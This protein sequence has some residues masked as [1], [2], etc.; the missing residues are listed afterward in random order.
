MNDEEF[1]FQHHVGICKAIV[2]PLRQRIIETLGPGSRNVSEMQSELGVSMSNLSNHLNILYAAGVVT[3]VKEGSFTLY[4]LSEP[5]LLDVLVRM[6]RVVAAIADRRGRQL[7]TGK[8]GR[9]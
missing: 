7:M 9:L 4:S 3:R 1:L 6:K 8:N 5:D 2:N